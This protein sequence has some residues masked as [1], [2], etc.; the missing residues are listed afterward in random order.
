MRSTD[1][2]I[3]GTIYIMIYIIMMGAFRSFPCSTVT[4]SSCFLSGPLLISVDVSKLMS[5]VD[6]FLDTKCVSVRVSINELDLVPNRIVAG[7]EGV[8]RN[9][10]LLATGESYNPVMLFDPSST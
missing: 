4:S 3:Q 6:S 5:Y 1:R 2:L 7:L 10:G 9:G 8:L